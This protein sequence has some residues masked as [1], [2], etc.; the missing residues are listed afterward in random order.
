MAPSCN[1]PTGSSISSRIT[2]SA[3]SIASRVVRSIFRSSIRRRRRSTSARC[4]PTA[5]A[6]GSSRP[7]S[8][9]VPPAA[10]IS[11]V[12]D[13]MKD[14]AETARRAAARAHLAH[15]RRRLRSARR[16]RHA[17]DVRAARHRTSRALRRPAQRSANPAA[18]AIWKGPLKW[19]GNLAI[20]GGIVGVAAHY[21]R[22]GPKKVEHESPSTAGGLA[23]GASPRFGPKKV[24]H[25]NPEA[26][27]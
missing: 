7:A 5:W 10:C 3:A 26:P 21:L 6:R 17:R 11:A 19:L 24:E 9:R 4:A 16:R 18:G 23:A 22:F 8:R 27:K 15:E 2:A 25:E 1:T 12:K 20:V 13:D 14:L